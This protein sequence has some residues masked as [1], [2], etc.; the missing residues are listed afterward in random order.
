MKSNTNIKYTPSE[1]ELYKLELAAERIN[2]LLKALDMADGAEELTDKTL[3]DLNAIIQT[4]IEW[5]VSDD[6]LG[7]KDQLL[8][9]Y[10]SMLSVEAFEEYKSEIE[11]DIEETSDRI[12]DLENQ[13]GDISNVLNNI[14]TQTNEVIEAQNFYIGGTGNEIT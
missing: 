4:I 5:D 8:N 9:I 10:N 13:M 14:L 7:V 2:A 12:G 6:A 1:N 11:N 3:E